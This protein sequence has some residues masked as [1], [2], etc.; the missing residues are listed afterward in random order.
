MFWYTKLGGRKFLIA[1]LSLMGT[2]IGLF[3]GQIADVQAG[4]VILGVLGLYGYSNNKNKEGP[5][6]GGGN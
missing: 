2:F 5:S 3:T 4:I 1:L 6:N